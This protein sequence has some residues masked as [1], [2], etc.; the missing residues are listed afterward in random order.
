MISPYRNRV[1]GSSPGLNGRSVEGRLGAMHSTQ[2]TRRDFLSLTGGGLAAGLPFASLAADKAPTCGLAIGTYGL[3]SLTIENAIRLVAETGFDGI[4]ITAFPGFTGDPEALNGRH[5]KDLRNQIADG[6]LR[7]CALMADLHPSAE[8]DRHAEQCKQLIRLVELAHELA[9]SPPVIQTVLAGK[10]WEDEKNLF[11]DRLADWLQIAVDQKGI[12]SIKPHRGHAMSKPEEA[13]WLFEQLGSTR[14][15]RMV[16]D[17]SHY[18]LREPGMSIEETVNTALPWT[19]YVAVKDAVE[20]DGK[21]RFAL[22]GEGKNW[23]HAD[24]IRAFHSGGYRGDFCC[25]VSSQ[26]WKSDPAYDPVVA[27]RTC[28]RNMVAAFERAGVKRD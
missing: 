28:Y 4:E 9:D 12:L 7:L 27:T 26:I 18:A 5:R 13:V 23:D 11:R 14:R 6:G 19:N 3:Q 25:E 20:V 2:S 17:Y 8:D 16:Y 21:V 15:L 10:S 22:A 24:V 1:H